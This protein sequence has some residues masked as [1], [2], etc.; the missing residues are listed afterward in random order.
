MSA[1]AQQVSGILLF[2]VVRNCGGVG[3]V[4]DI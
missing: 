4:P 1:N 2:A 3:H